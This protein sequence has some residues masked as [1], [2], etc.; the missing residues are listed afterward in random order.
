MNLK[1]LYAKAERLENFQ[2]QLEVIIFK[3][4][5]A[6]IRA[7]DKE[8]PK[9]YLSAPELLRLTAIVAE[10]GVPIEKLFGEK[11]DDHHDKVRNEIIQKYK[12]QGGVLTDTSL[13]VFFRY[14][15]I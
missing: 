9:R 1:A 10:F 6:I 4:K 5:Q 11:L 12:A 2:K 3:N 15:K 7:E 8:T 14:E 13:K